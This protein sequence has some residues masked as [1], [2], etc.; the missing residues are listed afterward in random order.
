[1][2]TVPPARDKTMTPEEVV[3][4]LHSGMTIGIGGWGR[5]ANPWPWYGRCSAPPSPT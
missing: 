1:M 3:A 4:R 2:S 5:A